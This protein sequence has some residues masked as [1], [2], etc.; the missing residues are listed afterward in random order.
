MEV[1]ERDCILY[2][3]KGDARIVWFDDKDSIL[4]FDDIPQNSPRWS[5]GVITSQKEALRSLQALTD[6]GWETQIF[7]LSSIMPK[8]KP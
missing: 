8:L 4:Y 2:A 6:G 5:Y 7:N 1:K 3:E